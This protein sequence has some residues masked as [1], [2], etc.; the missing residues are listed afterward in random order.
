MFSLVKESV[1]DVIDDFKIGHGSG[2]LSGYFVVE[3]DELLPLLEPS[4]GDEI[5]GHA[6][7]DGG[8]VVVFDEK[9]CELGFLIVED[10]FGG[11][12]GGFDCD[13]SLDD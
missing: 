9:L 1:V 5:D 7:H 13:E 4:F 2:V 6:L 12:F 11:E 10:L 8:V 3:G